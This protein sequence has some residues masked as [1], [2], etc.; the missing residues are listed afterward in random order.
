MFGVIYPPQVALVGFGTIVERPWAVDGMLGV[1]PV[2]PPRCRPTTG[3]ATAIAGAV[4]G[5]GDRRIADPDE[6]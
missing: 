4:P 5:R 1:P 6:L 3:P 2:S